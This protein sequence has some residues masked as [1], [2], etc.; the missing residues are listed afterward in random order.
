M[1]VDNIV[2]KGVVSIAP[3]AT[4]LSVRHVLSRDAAANQLVATLTIANTGTS[5]AVNVRLTGAVLGSPASSALPTLG[6]IPPGGSTSVVVRFPGSAGAPG[7][8][9]LLRVDGSYTGGTFGGSFRVTL[10]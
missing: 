4:A 3:Q 10:P 1:L 2:M 5:T 6:S 7:A 9:T 8:A